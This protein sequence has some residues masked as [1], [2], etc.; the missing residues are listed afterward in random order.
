M[1]RGQKGTPSRL[2]RT[3]LFTDIVRS[4]ELAVEKGDRA[5]RRLL[6]QHHKLVRYELRQHRGT[7]IDT[8][9]DG[10]FAIFENP[11]DAVR[12]AAAVVRRVRA[13]DL[14]VRAGIHTGEVEPSGDK[15]GG[16]AVHV[17][18]R[19]LSLAQPDEVIVS[20]TVHDL[21]SGSEL[22]FTDRGTTTLKGVPG[23]WQLYA[24]VPPESFDDELELA[25]G[26]AERRSTRRA[27]LVGAAVG[28][29]VVG[30]VLLAIV[31]VLLPRP[32][33]VV[34]A[35]DMALGYR[36]SDVS[37]VRGASTGRSPQ[38]LA[39]NGSEL[40]L[41]AVDA[42]VVTR[43]EPDNGSTENIGQVGLRPTSVA[44]HEDEVWVVGRFEDRITVLDVDD[45]RFLV[46]LDLHASDLT[47]AEGSLWATDDLADAVRRI[48][49]TTRQVLA[50]VAL[51]AGSGPTSIVAHD[52]L[53]WVSAAR[54]Q[55]LMQI[56][57]QTLLLAGV[58]VD[59]PGAGDIASAAGSIWVVSPSLDRLSRVDPTNGRVL[60]RIDVCD[61]PV[62]VA[63]D[64]TGAWVACS[65]ERALQH[66]GVDGT[67]GQSVRL[68]G[69][70]SSILLDA[71]V[72]WVTVRAD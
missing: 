34:A 70:P 8:A 11:T 24:L 61:S 49:P 21:V 45:G 57:P 50:S 51:P 28:S 39:A 58:G 14:Q 6:A 43:L 37:L 26:V 27:W 3:V 19:L 48:D 71:D 62:A 32:K 72:V 38:G 64:E 4:T 7:E 68:A 20:R 30:V 67:V 15:V 31:V 23:E 9:G 12:C 54:S 65:T 41:A 55:R 47:S 1:R 63:A 42:G 56:N 33:E 5:W 29:V 13:L 16:V 52:G 69:V 22:V 17:G 18:A 44:I 60:S 35:V 40:W 66:I 36:A 25:E 10:F 2:L 59:M 53:L 46:Q